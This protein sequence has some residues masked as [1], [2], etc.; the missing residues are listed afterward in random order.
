VGDF[1]RYEAALS[2]GHTYSWEQKWTAAVEAFEAALREFADKPAPYAG[3]GMAYFSLNQVDK[4]LHNYKLAAHYSRGDVIY[5]RQVADMQERLGHGQEAGQ[6]YMAIGEISLRQNETDQAVENWQRAASLE[7]ML[8]GAHQRL[9]KYYTTQR[10]LPLAI[11]E[12][13]AIAY[14]YQANN[15]NRKAYQTL[16]AAVQLDPRNAEVL[17]ALDLVQQG[18][19]LPAPRVVPV[20]NGN[21]STLLD[22]DSYGLFDWGGD[23]GLTSSADQ[24]FSLVEEAR[25]VAL[26]KLADEVFAEGVDAP[27]EA[28]LSGREQL[29]KPERDAIIT[30]A[31]DFQTRGLSNEAI[32]S[33][34]KAIGGGGGSSAAHFNLGLL[35]QEKQQFDDAIRALSIS[36]QDPTYL[37]ASHYALGECYQVRGQIDQ[38]LPH[39]VEVMQI[40]DRATVEEDQAERLDELYVQLASS[41]AA[42]G[43]QDRATAFIQALK[44]FLSRPGWEEKVKKAR[45]RLDALSSDHQLMILGDILAAGSERVLE[46]L[47]LTR[48]LESRHLINSAIE[49]A[50]RAISVAPDYMPAHIRLAELLA[51]AGLI[52]PAVNKYT[53]IGDTFLVR[54]DDN[55]A[56]SM[57][58]HVVDISPLDFA[59]RSRLVEMLIRHDQID[60]AL[61]HYLALGEAHYQFAQVDRAKETYQQALKLAPRGSAEKKWR[62]QLLRRIA[63]IDMQRFAWRQALT[64]YRELRR[65]D[66]TDER[67][68][69]TIIDLYFK[70]EQENLALHE[71]DLYLK[72]M[73]Q[74]GRGGAVAGILEDLVSRYPTSIGLAQRLSRLRLV[75]KQKKEA[76]AILDRLGEAQLEAG[77]IEAARST[78]ESIIRLDPP[79]VSSYRQLIRQL[80]QRAA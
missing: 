16:K 42:V 80:N 79:N 41:L 5:L 30:Q 57:Y 2:K 43:G 53:V 56:I 26:E 22:L 37:L 72:Q 50:L 47:Y 59:I 34:E 64:A 12:Y 39:Y 74:A 76:V 60:R 44:A 52:E 18:E 54:G 70:V 68:A 23:P 45:S 24:P 38:A 33:Y 15:E 55:G 69:L 48:E 3:L 58:E 77:Q 63:D 9:A 11:Q 31:L 36:V 67:T 66:P 14:I 28:G 25:R 40:V 75:Q 73:I 29:G 17:T 4:A 46:S 51:N 78:I 49:E 62:L 1:A 13:L 8:L 65:E 35:Y 61:H 7:P 10:Q 20:G 6:T 32:I 19:T 27:Y 71:L 21:K